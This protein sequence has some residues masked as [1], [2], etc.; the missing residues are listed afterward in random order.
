[1]PWA[2]GFWWAASH[3]SRGWH[4]Q[5]NCE[6]GDIGGS[7][8]RLA[9]VARPPHHSL[10]SGEA[11]WSSL[12]LPASCPPTPCRSCFSSLSGDGKAKEGEADPLITHPRGSGLSIWHTVCIKWLLSDWGKEYKQMP[13][14]FNTN[15]LVCLSSGPKAHLQRWS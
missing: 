7:S 15:L 9:P 6:G 5:G 1:M 12:C 2:W 11:L 10:V 14:G 8:H 13:S 3:Q 4:S